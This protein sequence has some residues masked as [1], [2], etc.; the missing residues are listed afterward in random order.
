[1]ALGAD[2]QARRE[3]ARRIAQP[4]PD[5][6]GL[7]AFVR[8]RRDAPQPLADLVEEDW[9]D[10]GRHLRPARLLRC[11]LQDARPALASTRPQVVD[12]ADDAAL[13]DDGYD[14]GDADLGSLLQGVFEPRTFEHRLVERDL[15]LRLGLGEALR[16]DRA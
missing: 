13:R 4:G 6:A 10:D 1:A 8:E 7:L 2:E 15:R 12:L 14:R 3:G 11:L 5:R 9:L 16:L